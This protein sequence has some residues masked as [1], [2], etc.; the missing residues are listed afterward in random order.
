MTVKELNEKDKQVY[1]YLESRFVNDP[2]EW[3]SKIEIINDLEHLFG[4][5]D[6]TSHD[7]CSTLNLIRIR[8]NN[9]ASYGLVEHII[10][11]DN[12]KFKIAK[13]KEEAKKYCQ[14]DYDNAMKLIVR[15]WL[16]I[17]VIKRDG[18][19]RLFDSEGNPVDENSLA[20]PFYSSFK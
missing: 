9:A 8:L 10:L 17:G 2:D 6:A 7:I 14:K 16:N 18:Q 11:L 15:Y 4:K 5:T 1:R 3:V 20:K 12:N 13:D 19:G